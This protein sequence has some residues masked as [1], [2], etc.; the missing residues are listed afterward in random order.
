[1]IRYNTNQGGVRHT[2]VFT[3][4]YT[5]VSYFVVVSNSRFQQEKNGLVS[6]MAL[7]TVVAQMQLQNIHY[8]TSGSTGQE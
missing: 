6:S 5:T 4:S 8:V 1:M 2:Y 3:Y 7:S